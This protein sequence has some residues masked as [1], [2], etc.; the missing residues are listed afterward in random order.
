ML[1]DIDELI[2][3]SIF[4]MIWKY[5]VSRRH[6]TFFFQTMCKI[7]RKDLGK[8]GL[9]RWLDGWE[10]L[11]LMQRTVVPFLPSTWQLTSVCNPNARRSN[12]LCWPLWEPGMYMVHM[13]TFRQNFHTY[14][15]KIHKSLVNSWARQHG[16][17]PCWVW[18]HIV[19]EMFVYKP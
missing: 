17:Q 6:S 11:L 8:V 1:E 7:L 10:N 18:M 3:E 5:I 12:A 14:K 15:I 13:H 2:G 16:R 4:G 9:E 19:V